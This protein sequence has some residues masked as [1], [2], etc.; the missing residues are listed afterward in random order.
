MLTKPLYRKLRKRL[1]SVGGKEVVL[2]GEDPHAEDILR[3][4]ILWPDLRKKVRGGEPHRCH[5]NAARLWLKD[6]SGKLSICTGYGLAAEIWVQ[7]TWIIDKKHIK[8]T[9]CV[10]DK[11]FGIQLND[12]E[13][14]KLAIA[15]LGREEVFGLIDDN[16]R[17]LEIVQRIV[18]GK[19]AKETA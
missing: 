9:V 4:G 18:E 3:D 10:Y 1:L 17:I 2:L 16:Q 7:H 12:N 19:H 11:Y 13:A 15:N 8:E 5:Q 14:L 6:K